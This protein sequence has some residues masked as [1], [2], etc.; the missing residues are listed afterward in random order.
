M[1]ICSIR[2]ESL[3]KVQLKRDD[4]ECLASVAETLG[5]VQDAVGVG[6]EADVAVVAQGR[7]GYLL[8][9]LGKVEELTSCGFALLSF[10][11]IVTFG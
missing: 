9:A 11:S 6:G 4:L 2:R 1:M 8:V 5:A 3:G 10:V 7:E